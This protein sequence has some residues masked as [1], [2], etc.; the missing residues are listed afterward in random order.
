MEKKPRTTIKTYMTGLFMP[1]TTPKGI[2]AA[3]VTWFTTYWAPIGAII[4]VVFIFVFADFVTGIWS[5]KKQKIKIVSHT[6]RN[7]VTK[8]SC[9]ML[10]I[11]LAFFLQ[12]EIIKFS[13]FEAVN[14]ASALICLAEFK[15]ILENMGY[16]TNST[17]FKTVYEKVSGLF[18]KKQ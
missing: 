2:L 5:A 8:L 3:L 4:V 18:E 15:S 17:I 6:M 13:W 16:I 7:S 14:F 9:Y 1:L 11:I 10:T 12:K